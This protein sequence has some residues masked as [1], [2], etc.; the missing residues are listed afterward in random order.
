MNR[1]YTQILIA[2]KNLYTKLYIS[3]TP[4][5]MENKET[6]KNNLLLPL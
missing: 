2:N 4:N 1:I 6:G 3:S 5:D